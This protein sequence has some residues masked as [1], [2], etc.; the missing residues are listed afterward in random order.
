MKNINQKNEPEEQDL[1]LDKYDNMI[2]LLKQINLYVGAIL[3]EPD[4]VKNSSYLRQYIKPMI[5]NFDKCVEEYN[6]ELIGKRNKFLPF[7]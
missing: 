7:L 2:Y 4:P 6:V 1:M 3:K 5:D